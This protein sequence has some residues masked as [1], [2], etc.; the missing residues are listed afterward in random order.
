MFQI[1]FIVEVNKF[2]LIRS[3]RFKRYF[4]K[5]LSRTSSKDEHLLHQQAPTVP[6][7]L[8][9]YLKVVVSVVS[10]PG[11]SAIQAMGP[12]LF[13]FN[14]LLFDFHDTSNGAIAF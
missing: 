5:S 6:N 4:Q 1:K 12:L 13:D 10:C 11:Y 2:S 8:S 7:W 14:K 3:E 9:E